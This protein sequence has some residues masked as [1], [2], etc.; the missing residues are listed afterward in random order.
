[1]GRYCDRRVHAD[2]IIST[3]NV[4]FMKAKFL[5]YTYWTL[6]QYLEKLDRYTTNA[7]MDRFEKGKKVSAAGLLFKAPF[8]FLGRYILRGGFL[9]GVPGLM[10]CML[11]SYYTFMRQA[12]LWALNHG[13]QQPDPEAEHLQ[14]ASMPIN[15]KLPSMPSAADRASRR[16]A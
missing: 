6:E 15:G 13:I 5:H 8:R 16:A 12:K 14:S 4:A 10:L 11:T 9:D 7:A 3:G 2:V 1:V